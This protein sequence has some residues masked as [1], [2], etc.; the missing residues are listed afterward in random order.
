MTY[1]VL[2]AV[3]TIQSVFPA[4]PLK[5]FPKSSALARGLA[6]AVMY[7]GLAALIVVLGVTFARGGA[8]VYADYQI[9]NTAQSVPGGRVDGGCRT[10]FYVVVTCEGTASYVASG[11][12]YTRPFYY[13]FFDLAGQQQ[14]LVRVVAD[15]AHPALVTTDLGL[16]HL[17][18]RALFLVCTLGF[19]VLLLVVGMRLIQRLQRAG[20]DAKML[21][22]QRLYPV[23]LPLL[24]RSETQLQ[25]RLADGL[26]RKWYFP[27]TMWKHIPLQDSATGQPYALAVAANPA[28]T[29]PVQPLDGNLTILDL[30][31]A[32]RDAV[33]NAIAKVAASQ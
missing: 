1:S 29:G 18:D 12:N 21:T 27:V 30:T 25:L 4:R 28:G 22:G 13:T 26:V 11:Q 9:S 33:W 3:S 7:C 17:V 31:D 19:L 24:Q 20:G 16:S 23:A 14:Y 15:P 8:D 2:S 32:E 5:L 10:K 6:Y